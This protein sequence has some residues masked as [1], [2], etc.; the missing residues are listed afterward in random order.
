MFDLF[1]GSN[2]DCS[3]VTRR[4]FLRIGGLSSLGLSLAG[5]LRLQ[6]ATKPIERKNVNCILMWMQGGPSHHETFDPKPD[7]PAEVRGEFNTIPTT[8]PGVRVAEHLPLLAR[9][10]D[11]YSIIRGHDP[12]NG[13]H[14][15]ADHLMMTGHKFNA[16]LPF[17]CFGSVVSKERGYRDGMFPFVQL[18]HYIDRRFNGG[19]AGFL[20][21]Q[22]NP[23]EVQDD[24]N[25][26]AFKVRDLSLA[27]D[28]DRQRLERRYAMLTDLDHYQQRVEEGAAN[29]R[30]RDIF[31]EKAHGLIT[32]PAAKR[33][34]DLRQESDRVRD[35]YGRT[36]FGQSCLLARRL[37]EAGVHFVT[38]TDGGWDTHQNNFKSLKE[39]K[40]PVLDRAYAALLQDLHERGLL[41]STLVVWFGDFGRTPKI[42][43]SAGR[44]HW[45]TAGVACMGGGG[46]KRGEVVGATNAL[47]EFVVDSPVSPQDLAATIYYALGIPLDT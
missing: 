42:N 43:P 39:R 20:G 2:K 30:A 38:V 26:P 44:D 4:G 34:F 37:I 41:D 8:L 27:S 10:T 9:Q 13:S 47:G 3:G 14:G 6:A 21:D 31:Y 36:T 17:P 40:L 24:P 35:A 5:F 32:S 15:T 19:I 16:S 25:V 33:A 1:S 22:Y 18:G 46:V 23:F 12:K 28:N 45:A 11:K 7:A 29:V